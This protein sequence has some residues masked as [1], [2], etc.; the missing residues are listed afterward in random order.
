MLKKIF[1]SKKV[2]KTHHTPQMRLREGVRVYAIGDIHGRRDLLEDMYSQVQSH[3]SEY[4]VERVIILFLGD[5]VDRGPDSRGVIDF[6]LSLEDGEALS[7]I[8]LIGNHEKAMLD[9]M[10]HPE[11]A[12]AW[13]SWGGDAAL[14]S[15]DVPMKNEKGKRKPPDKLAASLS[16]NVP[17]AHLKFLNNLKTHHIEDGYIFVHAGL[18]PGVEINK[19]TEDDML[20]IRE[21]FVYSKARFDKIVVFGHTIMEEPYYENG[22]LGIDTGAYATNILTC[23][24]LEGESV[25]ILQT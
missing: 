8:F 14:K 13:L 12:I 4:P 10:E 9:F 25:Q 5:Y 24:V 16:R 15:Y 11:E 20:T 21:E 1:G 18:R 3:I 7:H 22:R 23:A 2:I 19:Q 6:L 17:H